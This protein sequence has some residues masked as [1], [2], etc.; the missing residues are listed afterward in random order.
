MV[1]EDAGF[2]APLDP[3][4]PD[5]AHFGC[6]IRVIDTPGFGDSQLRDKQ[7][8]PLIQQRIHAA[9]TP[10]QGGLHCILMV[11]KVTAS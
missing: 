11:Y 6:P 7:F 8:M 9:A 10:E 3:H 5:K 1:Q 2:W 4:M